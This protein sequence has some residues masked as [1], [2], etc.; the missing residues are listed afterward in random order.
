MGM[1]VASLRT[2]KSAPIAIDLDYGVPPFSNRSISRSV[3][4]SLS[5]YVNCTCGVPLD[6]L[7]GMI[8]ISASP[9]MD[10]MGRAP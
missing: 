3:S 1:I 10:M 8:Q 4:L 6:D 5:N 9:K 7:T 2:L